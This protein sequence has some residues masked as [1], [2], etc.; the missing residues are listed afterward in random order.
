MDIEMEYKLKPIC[1]RML[2]MG[3]FHGDRKGI[4]PQHRFPVDFMG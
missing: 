4:C 1:E 2:K 3:I